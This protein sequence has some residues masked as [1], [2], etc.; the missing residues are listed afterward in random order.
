MLTRARRRPGATTPDLGFGP[1]VSIVGWI[2]DV[3][4]EGRAHVDFE[5]NAGGPLPA[6]SLLRCAP[7]ELAAAGPRPAVLLGFEGLDTSRP[8]ILG[9]LHER[10]SSEPA[11]P[12]VARLDGRRVELTAQQELVLR[13]GRASITMHA[14]GTIVIKGGELQS[15]ASGRNRITGSTV[16]IN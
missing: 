7:A 15:R 6:R 11:A 10:L 16:A 13:C 3:D 14:D 4:A 5:G 9:L 2:S 1:S 12:M 8:I